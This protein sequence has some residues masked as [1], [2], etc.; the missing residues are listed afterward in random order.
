MFKMMCDSCQ[1]WYHI[2]CTD[3][4]IEACNFLK[5]AAEKHRGIKWFCSKCVLD[6]IPS[7]EFFD[8]VTAKQDDKIDNMKKIFEQMQMKMD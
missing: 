2:E 6:P 1:N 8:E 7:A 5:E 3:L 4:D